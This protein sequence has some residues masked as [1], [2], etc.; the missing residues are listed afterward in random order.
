MTLTDERVLEQ[1]IIV[2]I[3]AQK[4]RHDTGVVISGEKVQRLIIRN[5]Y[6]NI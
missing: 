5:K 6:D 4:Q 1:D 2:I 3:L